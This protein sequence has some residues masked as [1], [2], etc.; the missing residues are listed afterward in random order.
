MAELE[1]EATDNPNSKYK[2]QWWK[3][4]FLENVGGS[5]QN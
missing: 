5:E 3:Q 1:I 2:E 4:M